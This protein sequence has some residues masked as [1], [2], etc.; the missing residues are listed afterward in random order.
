MIQLDILPTALAAAGVAS[1]P[2]WG[3]DGV[4][5]LP[6]P[7]RRDETAPRTTSLY[8]RLGGQAAIRRGDWKL[9]RYDKTVDT[10]GTRSNAAR[11][12][13]QPVP[14]VQPRRGRWRGP[15]PERRVSGA[16]PRI[17]SPPGKIWSGQLARRSGGPESTTTLET[18]ECERSSDR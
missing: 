18:E 1:E 14:P 16:R 3:L 6:L 8:W 12:S 13:A 15:R 4:D 10:P 17:C 5:L 2:E 11:T 7:D 9:V